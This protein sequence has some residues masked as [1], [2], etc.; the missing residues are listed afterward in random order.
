[1]VT[2]NI[3]FEPQ[4][5]LP[6]LSAGLRPPPVE[7]TQVFLDLQPPWRTME[8]RKNLVSKG[9]RYWSKA[10]LSTLLLSLTETHLHV[11]IQRPPDCG[12]GDLAPPSFLVF[13]S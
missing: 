11:S 7:Q 2:H 13:V 6:S 9:A 12:V 1:M 8:G 5:R 3:I 10:T 4:M